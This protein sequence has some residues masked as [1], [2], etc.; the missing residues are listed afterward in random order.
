MQTQLKGAIRGLTVD[1]FKNYVF[2]GGFEDGEIAVFDIEKPGKEKLFKQVA[3]LK[4]KL[5]ARYIE[6]SS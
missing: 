2:T 4:G 6:W 1:V 5:C 3:S